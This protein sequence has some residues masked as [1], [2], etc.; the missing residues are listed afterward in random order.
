MAAIGAA[1]AAAAVAGASPAD[2]APAAVDMAAAVPTA[3]PAAAAQAQLAAA[4]N[5]QNRRR[6]PI[7]QPT[8][9]RR[10]FSPYLRFLIANDYPYAASA[11]LHSWKGSALGDGQA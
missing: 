2:E 1:F 10:R 11:C 6:G 3:A 5:S 8:T 7:S 9:G 4:N